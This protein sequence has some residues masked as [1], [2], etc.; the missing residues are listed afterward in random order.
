VQQRAGIGQ[1]AERRESYCCRTDAAERERQT[2]RKTERTIEREAE[3]GTERLKE[4]CTLRGEIG[5]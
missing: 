3:R 5:F 1:V 2:E 4:G